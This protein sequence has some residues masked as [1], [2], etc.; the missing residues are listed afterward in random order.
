MHSVRTI[1]GLS[2]DI[3]AVADN[4]AIPLRVQ[5]VELE[6][7][8]AFEQFGQLATQR[9]IV[10]ETPIGE[11]EFIQRALMQLVLQQWMIAQQPRDFHAMDHST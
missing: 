11:L 2:V 10:D 4:L 3:G 7:Q 5:L 1:G 6:N 8:W 9:L